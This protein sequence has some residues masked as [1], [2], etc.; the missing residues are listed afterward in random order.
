[1]SYPK[2]FDRLD[3]RWK[4][5]DIIV[6]KADMRSGDPYQNLCDIID[7]PWHKP[8]FNARGMVLDTVS[9]FAQTGLSMSADVGNYTNKPIQFGRGKHLLT[10]PTEGDYRVA[11]RFAQEVTELAFDQPLDFCGVGH[12][13]V[14]AKGKKGTTGY[15]ILRAGMATVGGAQVSSYGGQY[16][17]YIYL[18][19]KSKQDKKTVVAQLSGDGI[20][21]AKVREDGSNPPE[22]AVVV[23]NNLEGMREFWLTRAIEAGLDLDDPE[24]TGYYRSAIYGEIGT[25]KTPLALAMPRLPLVYIAVDTNSEFLRSL[26]YELKVPYEPGLSEA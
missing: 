16:D 7:K 5:R 6:V 24:N 21:A 1:M 26:R 17:Q 19:Y 12:V 20:Y 3:I 15:S 13:G 8:P 14:E 11:Q 9:E 10:I 22:Q 2:P 25:G 23:P 18:K 4:W